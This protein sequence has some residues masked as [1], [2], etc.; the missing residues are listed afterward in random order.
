MNFNVNDW[1][2]DL[3]KKLEKTFG[4]RLLFIG[5]QGSYRRG[6]AKPT[7]DIDV[8]VILDELGIG[9]LKKYK[10]II[11][12]MPDNEKAC[13]F[14]SGKNEI[15]NWPK[16][17][18]FQFKNDTKAIFGSL[19]NLL[20]ELTKNDIETYI[21]TSSATLYHMVVH[22]YLY[23]KTYDNIKMVLKSLFFMFQ[24]VEYLRNGKYISTKKELIS[25]LPQDEKEMLE[26]NIDIL[27]E[28]EAEMFF[29]KLVKYL[30]KG[31]CS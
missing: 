16:M 24:A 18:I 1:I 27:S 13:G 9:D 20:P 6:E 29:D 19:D 14:I 26:I 12:A 11:G 22:S 23:D 15:K 31:F 28:I 21:K 5:L 8:V 25:L 7:S 17:E 3:A 30:S 2:N 10:Q 4:N